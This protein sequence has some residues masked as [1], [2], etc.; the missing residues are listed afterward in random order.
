MIYK[1]G[2]FYW[3]KFMWQGRMVCESTKQGN[4]KVARDM[5]S[6]HRTSLAKGIVGIREKRLAPTLREFINERVDPWAKARFKETPNTYVRWFRPGARVIC[7]YTSLSSR[8]LDEITGEHFASFAAYRQTQGLAVSS[9]NANLRVLSRIL[10]LAVEWGELAA[11]P[12][13]KL[14]TGERGRDRVVTPLEESQYLAAA[15]EPLRSIATVLFD[16]GMRPDESYRLRWE[17]IAWTAGRHGAIH[18]LYG[19]TRAARRWVPMTPRVRAVLETLWIS[20]SKPDAGY[21]WP[22]EAQDGYIND[23]TLRRMHLKVLKE[24]KVKHFVLH[25]LRH[26]FL[27]RLGES[28]CDVW[29]MARIVGHSSTKALAHYVHPSQNAAE[30]AILRLLPQGT[31]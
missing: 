9:V 26:T 18:I 17:T 31:N 14:L 2:K 11:M 25:S 12:K 22:S 28:G 15:P 19:K 29:T 30:D 20:A 10:R 16:T 13:V 23:E 1:R 21:V 7:A 24:A 27:T 4:A 3:Y 5:E 8:R 6:A